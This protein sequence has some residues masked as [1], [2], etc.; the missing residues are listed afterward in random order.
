MSHGDQ[1]SNHDV[2]VCS[3]QSPVKEKEPPRSQDKVPIEFI[4]AVSPVNEGT[5]PILPINN[6]P[7]SR[8]EDV[9]LPSEEASI[10][11]NVPLSNMEWVDRSAL[12]ILKQDFLLSSVQ[13]RLALNGIS[14]T[15]RRVK[16]FQVLV[17]FYDKRDMLAIIQHHKDLFELWF[18]DLIPY[19]QWWA[20]NTGCKWIKLSRV[21][22]HF[23]HHNF[24][25]ALVSHWDRL[26]L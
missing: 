5:L 7:N 2:L 16:N 10:M 20:S 1:P 8:V 22:I 23:W 19:K 6:V 9:L 25:I 18:E 15:V 14:A 13:S 4:E 17:T 12:R 21:P 3:I 11:F 26:L 24:F